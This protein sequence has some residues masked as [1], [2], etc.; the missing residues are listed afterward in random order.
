MQR[1]THWIALLALMGLALGL[2]MYHLETASFWLDEGF[3]ARLAALSPAEI[4][5]STALDVHPPLYY[6]LLHYWA[7]AFGFHEA[8]LRGFSV[9]SGML[10]LLGIY[11]LGR[12]LYRPYVGMLAVLLMSISVFHLQYC[13]EARPYALL[14]TLAIYSYLGYQTFFMRRHW[15]GWLLYVLA[16]VA[17]LYTHSYGLMLLGCQWLAWLVIWWF[18]AERPWQAWVKWLAAQ[19]C[20][21]AAYAPWL[22]VQLGQLAS[23]RE[24]IWLEPASFSDLAVLALHLGNAVVPAVLFVFL[25]GLAMLDVEPVGVPLLRHNGR[26]TLATVENQ[27]WTVQPQQLRQGFV[28][29]CWLLLPVAIL[30]VISRLSTPIFD[31]KSCLIIAP[32][33]YL[34]VA[35]GLSRIQNQTLWLSVV[36]L[37]LFFSG[38]TLWSHDT[39][40]VKPDWRGTVAE[41]EQLPSQQETVYVF[42]HYIERDIMRYYHSD[43][44]IQY[45][46]LPER[47]DAE[48]FNRVAVQVAERFAQQARPGERVWW[49]QGRFPRHLPILL[50]A[51]APLANVVYEHRIGPEDRPIVFLCFERK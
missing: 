38:A 32:A 40:A 25:A 42:P 46:G 16:T 28:L 27:M 31:F 9:L 48:G 29:C 14:T 19:L 8:A 36:L 12:R 11:W 24:G 17:M 43:A 10:G 1:H 37:I 30:F 41:F 22:P 21:V 13:Q 26:M 47:L 15:G 50:D 5:N 23:A 33:L 39:S 45:Q 51:M 3:S 18:T 7:G 6:L 49:V 35:R 34:L 4:I 44:Q 2:R 20:V